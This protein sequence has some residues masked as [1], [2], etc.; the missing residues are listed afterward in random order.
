MFGRVDLLV[1]CQHGDLAFTVTDSNSTAIFR[2]A[3]AVE[4]GVALGNLLAHDRHFGAGVD[5]P[6]VNE[7]LCVTRSEHTWMGW[8]PAG[9]INVLL[10][11]FEGHN[12]LVARVGA[13]QLDC[14]VHRRRQ[15]QFA[16]FTVLF[17]LTH[18][19]VNMH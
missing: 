3:K 13:P 18:S 1:A 8:A 19:W 12:R 10:G 2:P 11:T 6:N 7:A 9:V 16:H 14:P 4:R 15:E 17:A 5:V